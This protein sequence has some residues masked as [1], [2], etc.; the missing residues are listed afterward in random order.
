MALS[1]AQAQCGLSDYGVEHSRR[2]ARRGGADGGARGDDRFHRPDEA[3][4]GRNPGAFPDSRQVAA[5]DFRSGSDHSG[6]GGGRRRSGRGD[7]V[8]G[9]GAV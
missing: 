5:G 8:A 1:E 3:E 6:G 2:H 7:S 4:A 9:A